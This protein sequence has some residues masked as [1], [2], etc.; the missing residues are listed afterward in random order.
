MVSQVFEVN[1]HLYK[2]LLLLIESSY[3]SLTSAKE[4]GSTNHIIPKEGE[5][6]KHH[7]CTLYPNGISWENVSVPSVTYNAP[8]KFATGQKFHVLAVLGE[9]RTGRVLLCSSSTGRFIAAKIYLIEPST[10]TLYSDRRDEDERSRAEQKKNAFDELARWGKLNK[11]YLKFCR[12]IL[13]DSNWALT[14]PFFMPIRIIERKD[15][16]PKVKEA[17]LEMAK[18]HGYVFRK[19]EAKWR[20]FGEREGKIYLLDYESLVL[21][22]PSDY[23]RIVENQVKSLEER[24]GEPH[25][26]PH[27]RIFV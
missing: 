16:L 8:P 1:D 20:H 12:V 19:D 4:K 6:L 2:A 18:T 21:C 13:L 27:N 22:D 3:A 9:G 26:N 24:M 11:K 10:Q 14:M 15:T 25:Q 7:V 23:E 5:R 17:L